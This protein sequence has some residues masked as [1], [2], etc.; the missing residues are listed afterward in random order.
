ME[1][2]DPNTIDINK[3]SGKDRR[4]KSGFNIRSF[5]LGGRREKI[6]R[7]EDTRRIFYVDHYSPGLFA[8]IGHELAGIGAH[9]FIIFIIELAV[10]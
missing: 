7:R 5:L 3:R 8:A 2:T 9:K 4:N 10:I 1:M 6:H